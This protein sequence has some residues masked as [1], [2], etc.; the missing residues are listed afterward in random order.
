VLGWRDFRVIG[1]TVVLEHQGDIAF[2][3]W[4]IAFYREVIMGVLLDNVG[5]YRTLS[6]KGVASDVL[7]GDIA[8]FQQRDRHADFIG[9]LLLITAFYR[10][11]T[12]FF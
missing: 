11:G 4:L 10:Q 7:S 3:R 12:H 9:A 6:E 1:S 2:Q 5:G 8:G